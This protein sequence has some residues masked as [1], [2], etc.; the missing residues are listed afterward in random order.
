MR[1]STGIIEDSIFIEITDF[2]KGLPQDNPALGTGRGIENMKYRAAQIG[3]T[4]EIESNSNGTCV[5]LEL[6]VS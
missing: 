4:L 3:G 1:V 2:G 6:P 5:R